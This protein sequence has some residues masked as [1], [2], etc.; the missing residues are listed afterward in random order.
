MVQAFLQDQLIQL[1]L[2]NGCSGHI[3]HRMM[4][5]PLKLFSR[6]FSFSRPRSSDSYDRAIPPKRRRQL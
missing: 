2:G 6:A 3:I 4:C 1:E 5:W